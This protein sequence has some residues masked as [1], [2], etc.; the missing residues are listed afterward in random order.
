MAFLLALPPVG[1]SQTPA[2]SRLV[3]NTV[4]NSIKLNLGSKAPEPSVRVLD[5]NGRPVAEASVTFSIISPDPAGPGASFAGSA[6][7]LRVTT[8]ARGDA[9]ARGLRPNQ[10]PGR[11]IIEVQAE[12]PPMLAPETPVSMA[13]ENALEIRRLVMTPGDSFVNNLCKNTS[14]EPKVQVLDE[15]GNPVMG[16]DVTFRLPADGASGVFTGGSATR[17][18]STDDTGQAVVKG[19]VPNKTAGDFTIE[20]VASL[21]NL[22][23]SA[24][25]PGSN[26]KEGCSHTP[27]I[28]L[29][30]LAAA[31]G[32]TAALAA[33][34]G[35]SN[36]SPSPTPTPMPAPVPT[37]TIGS[38]GDPRFGGGH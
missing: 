27:L 20:A 18:A 38:G 29:L 30:V 11:Y 22:R 6:K 35:G 37:I 13:A 3:V 33:G 9:V 14:G 16:A 28:V 5:E 4:S 25:L 12:K 23:G 8:D 31:G 1:P 2:G 10:V 7:S 19:L 15:K 21:A 26:V 34:K 32:G 36:S 24:S 17:L